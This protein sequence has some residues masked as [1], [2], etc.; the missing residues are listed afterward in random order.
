MR[1]PKLGTT[2]WTVAVCLPTHDFRY[3]MGEYL[4]AWGESAHNPNLLVCAFSLGAL[5]QTATCAQCRAVVTIHY[6]TASVLA[7]KQLDAGVYHENELSL[8]TQ[9]QAN[10]PG[11]SAADLAFGTDKW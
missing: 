7:S 8:S 11:S 6:I 5:Q 1:S 4:N 10:R 9:L 2:G 3:Q